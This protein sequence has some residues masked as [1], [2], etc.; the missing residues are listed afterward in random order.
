[1]LKTS[2]FELI[3][4]FNWGH[5]SAR[6]YIYIIYRLYTYIFPSGKRGFL[7]KSVKGVPWKW[8]K[9]ALLQE[10]EKSDDANSAWPSVC[11]NETMFI[12]PIYFILVLKVM[13]S[14]ALF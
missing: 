13:L 6:L 1:M 11:Q 5:V 4:L 2:G 9:G 12:V 3:H 14:L 10:G 8:C 7:A